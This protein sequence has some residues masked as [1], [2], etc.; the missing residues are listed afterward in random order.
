LGTAAIRYYNRPTIQYAIHVR[1]TRSI[2]TAQARNCLTRCS[3]Q[4]SEE[5]AVKVF[6]IASKSV[7]D[8][9]TRIF[10]IVLQCIPDTLT[11][12]VLSNS[13]GQPL[14]HVSK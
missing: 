1:R 14:T 12:V 10:P 7:R 5:R 3:V 2:Y 4:F 6:E 8:E 9:M 13:L 11:R